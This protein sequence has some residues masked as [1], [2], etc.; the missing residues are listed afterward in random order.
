M[1]S[2]RLI[3]LA[4]LI[5]L[6]GCDWAPKKVIQVNPVQRDLRAK[7]VRREYKGRL[8]QPDHQDRRV[9]RGRQ[10]RQSELFASIAWLMRLAPLD[11]VAMQS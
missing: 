4:L 8:V 2:H 7:R 11:V 1:S 10:V 5:T 9:N 3:A 6:C